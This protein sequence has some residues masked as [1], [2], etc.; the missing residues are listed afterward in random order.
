[1]FDLQKKQGMR[2][3]FFYSFELFVLYQ[4]QNDKINRILFVL[5]KS[6][7]KRIKPDLKKSYSILMA[8][9]IREGN[10][11]KWRITNALVSMYMH[12]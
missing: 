3:D 1:M 2:C 11:M 10:G 9:K 7:K 6:V 12:S 8:Q 5:K 4:I